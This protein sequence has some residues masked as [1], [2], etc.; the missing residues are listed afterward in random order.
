MVTGQAAK[1]LLATP[2]FSETVNNLSTQIQELIINTALEEIN[3]RNNLY[4]LHRAVVG[5]VN[6]LTAAANVVPSIQE[7]EI[8]PDTSEDIEHTDLTLIPTED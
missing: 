6:I 2:V 1:E 3:K 5:I 8:P 7:N 4:L